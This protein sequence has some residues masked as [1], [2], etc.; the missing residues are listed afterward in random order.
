MKMSEE[1]KTK[2]G[3]T[4]PFY[5]HILKEM[6]LSIFLVG[7]LV[8]LSTLFP[9]ELGDKADPFSTPSHI[10]PEWY[11]LPGYQFLK[12]AEKFGFLGDWA[13]KVIGILG[14]AFPVLILLAVPWLDRG[15]DRLPGR[16]KLVLLLGVLFALSAVGLGL[17]GHFS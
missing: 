2:L 13:P 10:K 14:Q 7:V 3:W 16:R 9:P 17:W 11:F 4:T 1:E 15:P 12:V 6:I 5:Q 8:T